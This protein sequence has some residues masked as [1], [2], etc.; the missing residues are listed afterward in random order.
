MSLKRNRAGY[1]NDHKPPF[2]FYGTALPSLDSERRDDGTYVPLWKQEVRDERGR[3]RLHGA[4]TGGFSAGYFNTVGSKEGWSPSTFTSSKSQPQT[5]DAPLVNQYMDDEDLADL[6]QNQRLTTNES[7]AGLGRSTA[8]DDAPPSSLADLL[9]PVNNTIGVRL[10][11]KMGWRPG[12]GIG[13]RVKQAVAESHPTDALYSMAP[14]DSG[15]L[16][17]QRKS[18]RR[19]LGLARDDSRHVSQ[20][21]SYVD[22]PTMTKLEQVISRQNGIGVGVHNDDDSDED[23]FEVVPKTSYNKVIGGDRR[24]RRGGLFSAPTKKASSVTVTGHSTSNI[25]AKCHDGLVVLPGFVL[26]MRPSRR[27]LH[28]VYAPPAVPEDWQP[29][30]WPHTDSTKRPSSTEAAKA[31]TLDPAQRANLL[32]EALLPGKSVFDYM[33]PEARARLVAATGRTDLPQAKGEKAPEGYSQ[34]RED[35]QRRMFALIPRLDPKVASA[36]VQRA[37]SGWLPYTE[38]LDKRKRYRSFIEYS[39]GSATEVPSRAPSAN[40]QDWSN[41]MSE[42]VKA[43]QVFRPITGFMA[44]RFTT[45][46]AT[47]ASAM[48]TTSADG[49]HNTS[50]TASPAPT[51]TEKTDPAEQA[52]KIGMFGQ[53]TRITER[54]FPT[55]LT[56]KRFGVKPPDH[57]T[58]SDTSA[59]TQAADATRSSKPHHDTRLDVI[60]KPAMD[61]MMQELAATSASVTNTLAQSTFVSGGTQ[62]PD[63]PANTDVADVSAEH[64]ASRHIDGPLAINTERNEALESARAGDDMFKAVFGSDDEDD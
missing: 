8:D 31:S 49:D 58:A 7:Y 57:V 1:E 22:K 45:S 30:S 43:A 61:R 6:E 53:M 42:F 35:K 33:T 56:C 13:T 14:K 27:P 63:G 41:E 37:Q 10:L 46:S 3:K 44:S 12:Q 29:M 47:S 39:A 50:S 48:T 9:Q 18:D 34:S 62:S 38:D 59:E 21:A 28:N 23:P 15:L 52:A 5:R 19:G 17:Y 54:F 55:R 25:S 4:F 40:D 36:A 51:A 2:V 32:G 16:A 26:S 24:R 11:E 20:D 64:E 60:S